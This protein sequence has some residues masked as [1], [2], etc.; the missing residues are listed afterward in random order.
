MSLN[1]LGIR[2][3]VE[4]YEQHGRTF[5][6]QRDDLHTGGTKVRAL[7][8]VLQAGETYVYATPAV[9]HAQIALAVAG[10]EVGANVVL[11]VAQRGVPHA[12]TAY[13]AHMGAEVHQVPHGYLNVVQRAARLYVEA[14]QDSH[15]HLVPF[16]LHCDWFE[17]ALL[18]VVQKTCRVVTPSEVWCAAGSGVLTRTLQKAFPNI[19]HY[20]VRVG[21]AAD[22][23]GAIMLTAPEKYEQRTKRPPPFPSCSNYDAKVWQHFDY[24]AANGALYWNVAGDVPSV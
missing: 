18:Q 15:C 23:G 14:R 6:V 22:V 10:A 12:N 4:K 1:S 9:G 20:A 8:A 13:A 16:G 17:T 3:G 11:F 5:Y 7:K 24:H 21:K 19:P 2:S